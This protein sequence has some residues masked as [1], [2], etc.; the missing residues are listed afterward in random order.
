[1]GTITNIKCKDGTTSY[2]AEVRKEGHRVTKRFN[3]STDA[4]IWL[5]QKEAAIQTGTFQSPTKKYTLSQAIERYIAEALPASLKS[6]F[7]IN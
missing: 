2:K 5:R 3:R 6:A 4:K 1:M 7:L